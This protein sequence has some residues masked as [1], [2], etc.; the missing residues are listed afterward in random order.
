MAHVRKSIRDEIVTLVTGLTLTGSRVF[1]GRV[2]PL[3]SGK[4]P[5]VL[6]YT[7]NEASNIDSMGRNR[8]LERELDVVVEVY[9]QGTDTIDDSLD[10]ICVEVEEAIG[11]A[12]LTNAKDIYL[13]ATDI[14]V[15]GGEGDKVVG[16]ARLTYRAIYRTSPGDVETAL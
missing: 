13:T 16:A 6:V 5:G 3:A 2:Y 14:E 8:R 9:A 7:Q 12:T 4:L 11:A 10:A 15:E 1:P